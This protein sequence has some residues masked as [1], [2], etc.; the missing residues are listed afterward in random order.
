MKEEHYRT[1]EGDVLDEIC[2]RHYILDQVVNSTSYSQLSTAHDPEMLLQ[3]KYMLIQQGAASQSLD[4]V[5][6]WVLE[7]NPHLLAKRTSTE[8]YASLSLPVG[9]EIFLP[10]LP[11]QRAEKV[12]DVISLWD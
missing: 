11:L 10:A 12:I 5:L 8:L 6:D 7:N 3:T 9:I 1:R 4:V 2:W